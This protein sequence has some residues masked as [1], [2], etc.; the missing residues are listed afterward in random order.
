VALVG[1]V[2]TSQGVYTA[3]L[4]IDAITGEAK[5][6]VTLFEG[7]AK[8]AFEVN[9]GKKALAVIDQGNKVRDVKEPLSSL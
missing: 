8:D 5:P 3:V 6:V 7:Q 9:I 4:H 1:T 2:S